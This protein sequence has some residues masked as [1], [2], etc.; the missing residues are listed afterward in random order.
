M[1]PFTLHNVGDP[2]RSTVVDN[3]NCRVFGKLGR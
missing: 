3:F 1:V 2:F